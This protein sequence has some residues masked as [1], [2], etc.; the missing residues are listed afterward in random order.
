MLY[1]TLGLLLRGRRVVLDWTSCRRSGLRGR[2]WLRCRLAHLRVREIVDTNQL[3]GVANRCGSVSR[4]AFCL[5]T[6]AVSVGG[7]EFQRKLERPL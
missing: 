3:Q 5:P 6:W 7:D 4:G 1:G 2:S